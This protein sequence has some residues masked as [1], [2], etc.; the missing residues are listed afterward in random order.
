M[1]TTGNKTTFVRCNICNEKWLTIIDET[2]HRFICPDCSFVFPEIQ[3][4]N[5]ELTE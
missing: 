3:I 1:G 2:N 5:E 4:D